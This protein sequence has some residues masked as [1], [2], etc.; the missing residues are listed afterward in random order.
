[1]A[2][3]NTVS[4]SRGTQTRT[5]C[6]FSNGCC[7]LRHQSLPATRRLHL[8]LDTRAKVCGNR[9]NWEYNRSSKLS[10]FASSVRSRA[11]FE[12]HW[13]NWIELHLQPHYSLYTRSKSL[14]PAT[15]CHWL[16]LIPKTCFEGLD[17]VSESRAFPDIPVPGI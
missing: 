10:C 3:S 5:H 17:V 7:P 11:C 15:A 8:G 6:W 2:Q 12:S 4:F 9:R 13:L 14:P 1:M 16:M